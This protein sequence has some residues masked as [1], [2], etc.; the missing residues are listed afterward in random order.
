MN[1]QGK[2]RWGR[3]LGWVRLNLFS[4]IFNSALTLI[5]IAI[6]YFVFLPL[7]DW[8]FIDAQWSGSTP[9]DCPD[10]SAACWPFIWARLDQFIYGFYPQTERWRINLGVGLAVICSLPVFFRACP[11]KGIVVLLLS[12]LVYPLIGIFLFLGGVAGLPYVE[13]SQWGGFFLTMVTAVFVLITS[14]PLAVLLALARQ[15]TIP[16]LRIASTSWIELWRSVPALV[17]LF[18]AIIMFPLFMPEGWD[19]DKLLRALLALTI[20][21]SVYIAEALRGALLAIPREQYEAADALG[22]GYWQ[23]TCLVILPQVFPIA[24]PQITSTFIGLFKETTLLLIIGLFDFLGMVQTA[25]ADPG[26]QSQ[27]VS[28]TAYLFVALFFWIICF[29]LS[30]Y[31]AHLERISANAGNQH[32]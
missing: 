6:I 17:V 31:S 27:G 8:F 28:A 2:Q 14:L 21:M 22:L 4:S 13:T 25:I 23:R 18:V 20:L 1:K 11:H 5:S 29:G 10:K 26:W 24:L 32:D 16:L 30:R 19:I 7:F 12:L 15:S 9:Q 3:A